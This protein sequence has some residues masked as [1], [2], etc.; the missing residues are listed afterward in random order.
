MFGA[1]DFWEFQPHPE[2]WVLIVGLTALYVY[3][4]R[5]IGPR[6][7]PKGQ[8]VASVANKR[9]FALG[10]ILL[11]IS[12][13]WPMHDVAEK[14]L[15]SVHMFQHMILAFFVPPVMLLATPEWL[16][17]LVIGDGWI[18][19]WFLKL[20]RPIPA[21][22]VFNAVQLGTH[23][24]GLVNA[25]VDN[26]LLHYLL[27]AAVVVTALAVWMPVVSPLPEYRIAPLPQCIHLFFTSIAPTVPAAWLALAEGTVYDAYDKPER[28]FG[29]SVA[30]DQQL[31]GAI[32]KLGGGV[33]LW[34]LIIIIFFRY[35][36]AQ[37]KGTMARRVVVDDD[38][39]VI[40]ID[41][42]DALPETTGASSTKGR[43]PTS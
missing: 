38:G 11:W 40:S 32:M 35:S 23:W 18:G 36:A 6:V 41:D 5:S 21:A 9:W 31:A 8:A 37:N 24:S 15:Y 13:D 22:L 25:S 30:T 20:A 34:L 2:V 12:S 1:V 27:H 4:L 29:L 26:G 39:Q 3:A 33:F 17:R 19:R 16:A 42:L 43:H 7:V 10:L 28:M 14:Y